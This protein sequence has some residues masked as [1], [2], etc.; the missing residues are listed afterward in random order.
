MRWVLLCLPTGTMG[1]NSEIQ[2]ESRKKFP[3][4]Y[5]TVIHYIKNIEIA[6]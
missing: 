3:F 5:S 2:L 4:K 6:C 1:N